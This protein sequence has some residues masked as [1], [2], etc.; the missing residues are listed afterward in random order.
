MHPEQP[1]ACPYCEFTSDCHG[2]MVHHIIMS[3]AEQATE[4]EMDMPRPLRLSTCTPHLVAIKKFKQARAKR[5]Q[6]ADRLRE[7]QRERRANQSVETRLQARATGQRADE[8]RAGKR[9]CD[10]SKY[11][12]TPLRKYQKRF[13]EKSLATRAMRLRWRA[14]N[15]SRVRDSWRRCHV[16]HREKRLAYSRAYRVKNKVLRLQQIKHG[17]HLRGLNFA[18]PE[19]EAYEMMDSACHYCGGAPEETTKSG[20]HGFDR[21][22]NARGYSLDNTVPC[23]PNCNYMKAALSVDSFLNQVNRVYAHMQLHD[24]EMLETLAS[25]GNEELEDTVMQW[26]DGVTQAVLTNVEALREFGRNSQIDPL[27]L[28]DNTSRRLFRDKLQW[29]SCNVDD[30]NDM[31]EPVEG[32]IGDV[33]HTNGAR[34]VILDM[35]KDAD[36][37]FREFRRMSEKKYKVEWAGKAVWKLTDDEA[38]A[39]MYKNQ[40]TY[41]GFVG[42][43]GFDRLN[44]KGDYEVDN[45][46]P[47]C[48]SCN[49]MRGAVPVV[50][51]LDCV[52]RI[53]EHTPT[54]IASLQNDV[55]VHNWERRMRVTTMGM[56]LENQP[57]ALLHVH[58]RKCGRG[59]SGAWR[60][61]DVGRVR[62][63]FPTVTMCKICVASGD[64]EW[65]ADFKD[66]I[67]D[68]VPP[69]QDYTSLVKGIHPMRPDKFVITDTTQFYHTQT[70]RHS[71]VP[72]F[73][74]SKELVDQYMP[75]LKPCPTCV[76]FVEREPVFNGECGLRKVATYSE[77][78][79]ASEL[80]EETKRSAH[81]ARRR[82]A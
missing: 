25:V 16:A 58:T 28:F 48:A 6:D 64:E 76:T 29:M 81:N 31:V 4:E 52:K 17:A 71:V 41:C 10:T 37:V 57:K 22:D 75:F 40:C 26:G 27:V 79:L 1:H 54:R 50:C 78:V 36:L 18:V 7:Q 66:H 60:I 39:L 67:P 8:K 2:F 69:V 38:V 33:L 9:K 55:V 30:V 23:C 20:L 13:Q 32:L 3:H 47:A 15:Y 11:E 82:K 24:D 14:N 59:H 51:F 34:E 77:L 62:E 65:A 44:P 42:N 80:V 49:I 56:M 61:V 63:R 43:L 45:V 70:H 46:V 72:H 35:H 19:K 73:V 68:D 74:V 53:V 5:L 12:G 21:V